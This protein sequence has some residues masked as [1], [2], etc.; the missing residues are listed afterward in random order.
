VRQCGSVRQ[1]GNVLQCGSVR[2]CERQCVAVRA[3][4]YGSD[5]VVVCG[6]A[7][8]SVW[9]GAVPQCVRQ[10]A[11]VWQCGI[12]RLCGSVWQCAVVRQCAAV[13]AALCASAAVCDSARGSVRHCAWQCAAMWKCTEVRQY[14]GQCVALCGSAAVY[15]SVCGS[16]LQCVRQCAAVYRSVRGGSVWQYGNTAVCVIVRQCV[17]V[18]QRTAVRQCKQHCVA[19]YGSAAVCI[20]QRVRYSRRGAGCCATYIT[21]YYHQRERG[22][23]GGAGRAIGNA[24]HRVVIT[25]QRGAYK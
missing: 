8:G 22:A 25:N 16:V 18:L 12:V 17:I 1:C 10:C 23:A 11:S 9:Q 19:V 15:C 4:V 13:R 7:R 24:R 14:E 2:Q 3:T 6:C 5:G 21:V 20:N